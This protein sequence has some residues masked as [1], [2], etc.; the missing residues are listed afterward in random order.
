MLRT[1]FKNF[2]ELRNWPD[3]AGHLQFQR[4]LKRFNMM[5]PK[6]ISVIVSLVEA[7]GDWDH[8]DANWDDGDFSFR[9]FPRDFS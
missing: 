6:I 7:F 4:T 1:Q 2:G 3:S 9:N 8:N 5:V